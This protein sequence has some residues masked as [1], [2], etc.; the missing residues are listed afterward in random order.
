MGGVG[1]AT[2]RRSGVLGCIIGPLAR[3]GRAFGLSAAEVDARATVDEDDLRAAVAD[4]DARA[5]VDVEGV[6]A[7]VKNDHA[8]AAMDDHDGRAAVDDFAIVVTTEESID[9]DPEFALS[10]FQYKSKKRAK[11]KIRTTDSVRSGV[12]CSLISEAH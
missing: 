4:D 8:R 12:I 9:L 5:S 7:A 2:S 10:V 1:G 6:R 11:V 3:P